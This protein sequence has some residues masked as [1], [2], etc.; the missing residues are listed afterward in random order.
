M[1]FL[2]L[3]LLQVPYF[4]RP[5]DPEADLQRLNKEIRSGQLQHEYWRKQVSL[6]TRVNE[7]KDAIE[8]LTLLSKHQ[9][10]DPVFLDANMIAHSLAGKNEEAVKL[11]RALL[12]RFPNYGPG[13]IN[14]ARIYAAEKNSSQALNLM[15]SYLERKPLRSADWQLILTI[16]DSAELEPD[17][18]L[19]L[20]DKKIGTFP[21]AHSLHELL[22]VLL[23]RYGQYD[24]ARIWLEKNP[25]LH[26]SPEMGSFLITLQEFAQ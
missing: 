3:C 6:Y 24:R 12:Y 4:E 2:F 20:L 23:V 22:L 19:Q 17:P 1:V 11:G 9:P 13:M 16:V 7:L 25:H 10:D 18:L 8:L 21:E 14:L 5:V 15:L 26:E